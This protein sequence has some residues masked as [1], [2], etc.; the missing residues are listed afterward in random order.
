MLF[1]LLGSLSSCQ[2]G[3]GQ[4]R[5]LTYNVQN[6]FDEVEDGAEYAEFRAY[7]LRLYEQHL[8]NLATVFE[9][10]SRKHG[11]LGVVF[12]QEM[13]NEEVAK[14]L[15]VQTPALQGMQVV[16]TKEPGQAIG[17]G[18]LVRYPLVA[19]EVFNPSNGEYKGLRS[20]V[21]IVVKIKGQKVGLVTSHLPS[22]RNE[23]NV[24]R[25]AHVLHEMQGAAQRLVDEYGS[26]PVVMAGDF[27]TNLAAL[28]GNEV[29]V[30]FLPK[31]EEDT[32]V[33]FNPWPALATK[34]REQ[35]LAVSGSYAFRGEWTALDGFLLSE[36]LLTG[37]GLRFVKMDVVDFAWLVVPDGQHEGAVRPHVF[38]AK[39]AQGFSDH[40]PVLA[41]FK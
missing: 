29:E 19:V 33:F 1:W 34:R 24:R 21:A 28:E 39:S 4:E 11:K 6:L 32:M 37:N 22:Q 30:A 16:F 26:M 8:V 12:L 10:I 27:N 13:E 38:G 18:L 40:L 14:A 35:G 31:D 41:V 36:G 2:A 23:A 17:V 20:I 3:R 25:R 5:F 7:D 15:V 9:Q